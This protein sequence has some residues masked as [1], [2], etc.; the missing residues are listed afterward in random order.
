MNIIDDAE[1]EILKLVNLSQLFD[2][3]HDDDGVK[4][5][6]TS[7]DVDFSKHIQPLVDLS[8]HVVEYTI[9]NMLVCLNISHPS[10]SWS[11]IHLTQLLVLVLQAGVS[12]SH[13]DVLVA[14]HC[15]HCGGS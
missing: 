14:V 5:L 7:E 11:E 13:W 15:T 9:S 4:Y 6:L 12:F 2:F 8:W 3:K 1:L 10:H